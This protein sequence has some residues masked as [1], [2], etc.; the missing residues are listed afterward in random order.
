[1]RSDERTAMIAS[2]CES[3]AEFDYANTLKSF[4]A[5]IGFV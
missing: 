2:N 4:L 5:N 1:M 3:V